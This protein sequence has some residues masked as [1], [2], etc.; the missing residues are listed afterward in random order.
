MEGF[1]VPLCGV[2]KVDPDKT[3]N[4]NSGQCSRETVSGR[5][6]P[7]ALASCWWILHQIGPVATW[8]APV[9]RRDHSGIELYRLPSWPPVREL[10]P[11]APDLTNEQGLRL[12]R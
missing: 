4:E 6:N 10:Y 1:A 7:R 9:S 12:G 5:D 2:V 11:F 8:P 3:T